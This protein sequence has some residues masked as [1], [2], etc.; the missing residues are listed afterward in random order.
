MVQL[1]KYG[2]SGNVSIKIH[3]AFRN[4]ANAKPADWNYENNKLTGIPQLLIIED[5]GY[6]FRDCP[7]GWPEA[8]EEPGNQLQHIILKTGKF[9]L[10]NKL[11]Q[12]IHANNLSHKTTL[13]VSL[14]D[15]RTCAVKIGLSLSWERIL[16][17]TF[18]AIYSRQCLPLI[19]SFGDPIPF[20][21]IIVTISTSGAIII[22]N[23]R[24]TLIFD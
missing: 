18:N 22:E 11:I 4:G 1:Q 19:S 7:E 20:R 17:E 12:F 15:I 6:G 14:N 13:I 24:K 2:R 23:D 16:E 3:F 9:E 10:K 21:R 5:N 8:L